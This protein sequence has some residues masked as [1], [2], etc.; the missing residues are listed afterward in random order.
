MADKALDS[1]LGNL[2]D[3]LANLGGSSVVASGT[4]AHCLN[5]IIGPLIEASGKRFH[6]EHFVC[7]SCKVTLH[8]KEY[9]EPDGAINCKDCYHKQ[10]PLCAKCGGKIL[11]RAVVLVDIQ[12]A[13][14]PEHFSCAT[15]GI[16]LEGKEFYTQ[17]G[18]PYC[19]KDYHNTFAPSCVACK[20]PVQGELVTTPNNLRYH[21][22]CFVCSSPGCGKRLVGVPYYEN[23]ERVYCEAHHRSVSALRCPCGKPIQ[24][25]YVS[26]LGKTWHI[27]HFICTNCGKQLMGG[28]F[29]ENE[30]RAFCVQCDEKLFP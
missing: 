17:N 23:N 28:E 18:K 24:G 8:G 11:T 5:P 12:K 6:P 22:A 29:S 25:Q 20:K 19:D 16:L 21:P 1:L 2:N 30:G 10:L 27:E 14:H 26:A 3:Q 7:S 4:C 15:C 9:Y 13:W